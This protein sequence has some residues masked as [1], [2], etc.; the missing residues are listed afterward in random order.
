MPDSTPDSAADLLDQVL[1]P[2]LDDFQ[3]S[4]ER[5]FI[6]LQAC[7]EAVLSTSLQNDLRRRLELASAELR[8]ARALRQAAPI[9]MAL[10]MKV[11]Q[12]WHQLVL[13][14]WALSAARRRAP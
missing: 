7:P 4:F 13:E 10:D 11:I 1:N 5:G 12:P 2:L 9:P 3:E 8:S 14:V 6:L